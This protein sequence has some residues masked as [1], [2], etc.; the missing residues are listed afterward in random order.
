MTLKHHLLRSRVRILNYPR[1]QHKAATLRKDNTS[2][3]RV[4]TLLG[5]L[6][7]II[8]LR[9]LRLD[10]RGQVHI[11]RQQLDSLL[12]QVRVRVL[13]RLVRHAVQ[14]RGHTAIV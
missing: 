14:V 9:W 7:E 1:L 10:G 12:G 2:V 8:L 6:K 11:L 5:N 13:Q 3:L 4:L